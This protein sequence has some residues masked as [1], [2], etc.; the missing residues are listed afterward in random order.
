MFDSKVYWV[1]LFMALAGDFIVAYIL[2]VFYPGYSHTKHVMSLLGSPQ[3]PVS[4]I[5]N[6][7]LVV[8][9]LLFIVSA[10]FFRSAYKDISLGCANFG[11]VI[12]LLYGIGAG[13]LAGIFSVNESNELET[14]ASK[15]HGV[16]S[17]IGFMALAFMPLVVSILFYKQNDNLLGTISLILFILTLFFFVL[18]V[19]SEKKSFQNSIIALS[20]LWQRLLLL[21]M[22]APL[23]LITMKHIQPSW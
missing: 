10:C 5:Y 22:Y 2:S 9:G 18:F 12:M 13:V 19:L 15:I 16:G 1:L 4:L 8:L 7:W 20:G 11:F 6:V 21:S 3:S 14:I 23:A 17:G